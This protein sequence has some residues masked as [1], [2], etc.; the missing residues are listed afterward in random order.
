MLVRCQSHR[1]GIRV[2]V[3]A[4]IRRFDSHVINAMLVEQM[5]GEVC[6][7]STVAVFGHAV[8][9][10]DPSHPESRAED[11]RKKG[12]CNN[13]EDHVTIVT[14]PDN[15]CTARSAHRLRRAA[16][17]GHENRVSF[18]SSIAVGAVAT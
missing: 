8:A 16:R 17:I 18:R 6:A 1:L 12:N 13:D 11:E 10:E 9:F 4:G 3:I 15:F 2:V 7:S 14:S 5:A